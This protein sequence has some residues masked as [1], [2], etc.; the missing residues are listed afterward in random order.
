MRIPWSKSKPGEPVIEHCQHIDDPTAGELQGGE[1]EGGA[2]PARP[3]SPRFLEE[4]LD[5][6]S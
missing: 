2:P 6:Y 1:E 4:T 3:P 5:D